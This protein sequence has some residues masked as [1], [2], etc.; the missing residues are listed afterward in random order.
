[1]CVCVRVCM[2][3]VGGGGGVGGGKG[4]DV[5]ARFVYFD[6]GSLSNPVD[7]LKKNPVK[8]KEKKRSL[9]L[10]LICL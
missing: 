7:S 6:V 4:T 10:S 3:Y 8:K 5:D 2:W 9:L 1:M